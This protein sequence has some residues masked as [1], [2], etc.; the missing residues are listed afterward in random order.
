MDMYK[1]EGWRLNHHL[2]LESQRRKVKKGKKKKIYNECHPKRIKWT[3]RKTK[4]LKKKT[5]VEVLLVEF[6]EI[7]VV[8]QMIK[9]L[10]KKKR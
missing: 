3:I 1:F 6:I 2:N 10:T 5:V 7:E 4:N 9:Y 8:A